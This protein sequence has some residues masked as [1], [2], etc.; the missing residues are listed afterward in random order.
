MKEITIHSKVVYDGKIIQVTKD[1]VRLANNAHDIR[2]V[3]H[4]NGGVAVLAL[5]SDEQVILIK[6]FRYPSKEVLYELPAGRQEAQESLMETGARELLEETGYVSNDWHYLGY[7][8]PTVAYVDETIHV[9][10]ANNCEYH[11]QQ[12]DENEFCETCIVSLDQ[13]LQFVYSNV[14][15]DAKTIIALLKY[16]VYK[17]AYTT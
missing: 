10:L 14:I 3:V 7:I 15:K 11:K 1:E 8:Y 4:N 16:K 17:D 12:L 6:Q 5:T 13:A 9:T 2:E